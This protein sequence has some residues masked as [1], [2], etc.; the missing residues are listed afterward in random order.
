MNRLAGESSP[1]LL[2][3]A[4]NPVDWY[5]WGEE[6]FER[7]RQEDRPVL[8]SIGYAACH[9][10]HVMAHESFEDAETAA[11][12]NRLF[13]NVKVDREERPDVDSIYM[14]AVQ[15]MSGHGG[16]PMTMFLT[17]SGEPFFGGTYFPPEDRHGMP[18]F[19]RILESVANAWHN[20]REQV[21]A[22]SESVRELYESASAPLASTGKLSSELLARAVRGIASGYDELNAGFGGAP[23]FPPTMT[24]D[25]LLQHWRRTGDEQALRMVEATWRAMCRG[26]LHDHIGGG[27]HR[28]C[29]DAQ[30]GVPHFEKMLYDNALLVRLGTHLWQATASEDARTVTERAL[31][32]LAREMTGPEGGF[33]SSLDADTEGEEG[34]FY[35]WTP[36]E[37]QDALGHQAELV[38][39][40]YGVTPHGNFEG[41][42]VLHEP[43]DPEALASL[44]G[45]PLNRLLEEVDEAR[46][47]LLN[48]REAR[49]R[50]ALDNK[51][52]AEWNGLMLRGAATAARAFNREADRD[53][54]LR[55][56]EFLRD[57][58]VRDGRVLRVWSH[59]TG[60]RIPGMLSDH[61]A[62]ALAFLDV[63]AATL[64]PEW[65]AAADAIAT[66]CA[67]H[68]WQEDAG[69]FFDTA[70]DADPLITR[71]RDV[72]DNALPSG[73]SLAC[74]LFLTLDALLRRPSL[75]RIAE[76]VLEALAEP[77]ARHGTAF[78]HQLTNAARA[79]HGFVEVALIR[80][81]P[82][83]GLEELRAVADG[84]Y[85]PGLILAGPDPQSDIALLAGRLP[86][87][88]QDTAYVCRHRT[89]EMPT[90]DSAKFREQLESA[91]VS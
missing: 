10:C 57:N 22:A 14:Q 56:A 21:T 39:A 87:G 47:R 63:H 49:T 50:P 19:R 31:D 68:F 44:T 6:A 79:V 27:F 80:G 16:W 2:Q 58:M 43:N 26:G 54:A 4:G 69:S 59:G 60:A 77:M 18:S 52:I 74:E 11:L 46:P 30:W 12:M 32:W 75:R 91:V 65:I 82:A 17:P 28:Y 88:S 1:Y 34:L 55:N 37:L 72:T 25:F 7:A 90:A 42:T 41:S 24:L 40:W 53:M 23:K 5:P 48:A 70:A 3:H 35:V 8:L 62:I 13:V 20:R 78:G 89:C 76:T 33:Y 61:A 38:A 15:A 51:V 84:T 86:L 85:L 83:S 67:E 73:T 66:S 81:N 9:W 64:Q 71:P 36:S 45:V 29:V